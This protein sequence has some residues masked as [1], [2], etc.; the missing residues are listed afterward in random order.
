M[1]APT[2]PSD[3]VTDDEIRE[4]FD[5]KC[6]DLKALRAER[7]S[8]EKRVAELLSYGTAERSRA[9]ALAAQLPEG[10]K[11]CTI[12]FKE[13]E[14]GHGWLTATN[15][16]QLGCPTCKRDALAEQNRYLAERVLV[17]TK[18]NGELIAE[19]DALRRIVEVRDI[20]IELVRR[21]LMNPPW[22]GEDIKHAEAIYE[23]RIPTTKKGTQ[24]L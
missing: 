10:M 21:R 18:R 17:E 2:R 24:W 23:S 22:F 9:D 16:E 3:F 14:E 11:H 5:G 15:R 13:C 1:S 12:Q 20:F 19:R 4:S 6:H 7:D 8:A